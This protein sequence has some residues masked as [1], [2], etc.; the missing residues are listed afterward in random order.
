[1]P[2]Y[3][4][5]PQV[6][7]G[8]QQI[9]T[10]DEKQL[11]S[12]GNIFTAIESEENLREAT[13]KS[14]PEIG[15]SIQDVETIIR[16]LISMSGIY[17][18]SKDTPE[19][20]SE[21]FTQSFSLHANNT[22]KDELAQFKKNI[23]YLLSRIGVK[24]RRI[25]K[26]REVITENQ[27]NFFES[28]IISDIRIVFDDDN[29]L[30]KADQLAVIVHN[31]RIRYASNA[32]PRGEI[33]ISLDIADLHHLQKVIDRAIEKDKVMRTNAHKLTFIDPK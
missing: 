20:F 18:E 11:N 1:M 22:N 21:D 17:S 33:F 4:I 19:K 29:N 23:T 30:D 16:A 13:G 31:L 27:N 25:I 8:L 3:G 32:S 9:I 5:P 15:I 10:L 12:V 26:T 6:I 28:R 7:P 14:A 24:M 2:M